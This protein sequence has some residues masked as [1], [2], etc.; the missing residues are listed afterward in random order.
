MRTADVTR[1]PGN[2]T[3]ELLFH[4]DRENFVK[5]IMPYLQHCRDSSRISGRVADMSFPD[6]LVV[7]FSSD[8]GTIDVHQGRPFFGCCIKWRPLFSLPI[9]RRTVTIASDEA[10]RDVI[11]SIYDDES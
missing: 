11:Y 4:V 2:D 1:Y 9:R 8:E 10:L 7:W 5:F 6:G 3:F